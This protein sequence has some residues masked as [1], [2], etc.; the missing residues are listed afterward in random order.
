MAKALDGLQT[1]KELGLK[2]LRNL[3]A[4]ERR[5]QLDEI[6]A[7]STAE[8]ALALLEQHM[9]FS[10]P[11][12]TVLVKTTHIGD[13]SIVRDKLAHIVEKRVDARERYVKL[14]LDT[15]EQPYEIWETM[16]DDG[17]VRYIFIGMYKQKQQMLVVVAPWDG[18]VL[19]NFMHTEAKGLNKHRRGNLLY[20][21]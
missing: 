20:S 8:E 11:E 6:A 12:M 10:S 13:M 17:M 18:K 15:L 2:D 5:D 4:E 3:D 16:Y 7:G 19:W 14:A 1:F 21:R 9:G